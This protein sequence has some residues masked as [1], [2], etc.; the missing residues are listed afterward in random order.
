MAVKWNYITLHYSYLEWPKVQ[1]LL[2]HNYTRCAE[3]ETENRKEIIGKRDKFWGGFEKQTALKVRW[4]RVA[5]C[6]RDGIRQPEMHDYQQWIAVY[7]G[8]LE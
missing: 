1:I 6:S 2:N 8:W 3:L 4:R 7:V 5:D